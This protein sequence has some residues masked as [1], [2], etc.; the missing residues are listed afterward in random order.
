MSVAQKIK[1]LIELG[2]TQEAIAEHSGIYQSKVSRLATG[3]TKHP[4][5][6]DVKAIEGLYEW[7][8]VEGCHWDNYKMGEVAVSET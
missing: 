5:Y 6:S 3:A 8:A 7:V 4:R 1:E 2:M